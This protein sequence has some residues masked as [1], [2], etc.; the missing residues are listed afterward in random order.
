MARRAIAMVVALVGL[1]SFALPFFVVRYKQ[2]PVIQFTGIE[3][4]QG[5]SFH[6]RLEYGGDAVLPP[7]LAI[8]PAAWL[9][10]LAILISGILLFREGRWRNVM[11]RA[12]AL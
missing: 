11:G 6:H 5:T 8:V 3:L 12:S 4:L 7:P 10:F 1:A 2:Q 9:A